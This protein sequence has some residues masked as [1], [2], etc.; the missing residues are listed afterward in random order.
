MSYPCEPLQHF[1]YENFNLLSNIHALPGTTN[2]ERTGQHI[3]LSYKIIEL[4]ISD[5]S[6]NTAITRPE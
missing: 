4:L 1:D 3:V 5:I 6:Y 2:L